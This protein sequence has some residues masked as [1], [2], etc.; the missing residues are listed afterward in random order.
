MRLS[1]CSTTA[2]SWRTGSDLAA[3][4]SA[5]SGPAD[6]RPRRPLQAQ[7]RATAPLAGPVEGA[8]AHDEAPCAEALSAGRWCR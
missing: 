4:W 8:G 1:D 5:T 2:L 6:S 7:C 3:S